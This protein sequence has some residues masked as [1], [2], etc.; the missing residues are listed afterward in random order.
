M[1]THLDFS[2]SVIQRVSS[3][4]FHFRFVI[5]I[6]IPLAPQEAL[7]ILFIFNHQRNKASPAFCVDQDAG[8]H[9]NDIA[10]GPS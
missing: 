8:D 10:Y 9:P 2:N 5:L 1:S 3:F 6:L 4:P 7:V